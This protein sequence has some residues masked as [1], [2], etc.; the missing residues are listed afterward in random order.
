MTPVGGKVGHRFFKHDQGIVFKKQFQL[1]TGKH[2]ATLSLKNAGLSAF[3][4]ADE[5]FLFYLFH[6]TRALLKNASLI[7]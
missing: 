1:K 4:P 3:L 5:I 2:S 6:G 7:Y